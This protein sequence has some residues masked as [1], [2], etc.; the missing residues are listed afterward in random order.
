M[1]SFNRRTVFAA[2]CA[3]LLAAAV[4]PHAAQAAP[5][6][7]AAQMADFFTG[8]LQIELAGGEWSARRF[9]AADHTYRET[10]SDGE[11]HGTWAIKDGKVCTTADQLLG[12]DRAR[13]YC[14]TG[15]GR[16]AGEAWKDNDPVTGNAVLFK[17]TPGR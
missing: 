14:N 2:A 13:T 11:V 12:V 4:A 10:G 7:E 15:V 17:L 9:L 16:K 5:A 6:V 1:P 3:S 8:T